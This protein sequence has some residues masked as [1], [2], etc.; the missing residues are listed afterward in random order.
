MI[1]GRPDN[2]AFVTAKEIVVARM[3]NAEHKIN[4]ES[5]EHVDEYFKAIYEKLL[6]ITK[7][8]NE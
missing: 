3:N 4:S 7:P 8:E 2:L 5:G 1:T 6:E